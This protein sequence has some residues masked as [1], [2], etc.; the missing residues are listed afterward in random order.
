MITD[1]AIQVEVCEGGKL[2]TKAHVEDAGYD[3]YAT[4]DFIVKPGEIV[5]HPLNVKLQLPYSSYAEITSKSGNGVKGLLVY[6]GIIDEGYRGVI[7][8]VMTNILR[9]SFFSQLK[10]LFKKD[11]PWNLQ[12]KSGMKLSQLIVHPYTSNWVLIQVNKVGG[13]TSRGSG[14]FGSSGSSLVKVPT[15]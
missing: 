10:Y 7:N 5:K 4:S 9:P 8:V 3:L 6:A 13:N 1:I 15:L 11:K 2:P 12:F 14:G